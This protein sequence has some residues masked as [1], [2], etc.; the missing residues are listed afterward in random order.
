MHDAA[1]HLLHLGH[2]RIAEI[3][4]P[5]QRSTAGRVSGPVSL[6]QL[7]NSERANVW[8]RS[9][10]LRDV[11]EPVV[12]WAAIGASVEAGREAAHAV[13]EQYWDVSP[14][15]RVTA[16][17]A[18]SDMLAAGVLLALRD[19]GIKPG[20][21]I[22]VVGFDGLDLPWLAPEKLTTVQQPLHRKGE[23][24]AAAALELIAGGEPAETYLPVELV[25]GTTTGPPPAPFSC[26]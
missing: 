5:L 22:S 20:A 16:I 6:A 24:L 4:F 9:A 23:L 19:R 3:T 15:Q 11:M 12:S 2:R 21:E 14:E 25:V 17:V 18:Q 8:Q 26:K 10:G 13:L 7:Q 1:A